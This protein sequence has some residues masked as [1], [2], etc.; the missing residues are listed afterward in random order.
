MGNKGLLEPRGSGGKH[1]H[2]RDA[3]SILVRSF[4]HHSQDN[5]RQQT[6]CSMAQVEQNVSVHR[7][8]VHILHMA[9]HAIACPEIPQQL[10]LGLGLAPSSSTARP[11]LEFA[12]TAKHSA[13]RYLRCVS[14]SHPVDLQVVAFREVQWEAGI[15]VRGVSPRQ[16]A[17]PSVHSAPLVPLL[18]PAHYD[19]TRQQGHQ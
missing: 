12:Q 13:Q 17:L 7:Y 8:I 19:S 1:N 2:S 11:Q 4:T 15:R 16:S 18:P 9:W 10:C 14:T 3:I 5:T 6:P